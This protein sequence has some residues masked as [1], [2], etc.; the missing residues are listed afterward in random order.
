M[1][2][3]LVVNDSIYMLQYFHIKQN[4]DLFKS[5][6]AFEC[7]IKDASELRDVFVHEIQFDETEY[8]RVMKMIV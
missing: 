1:H 6:H 5:F 3:L 4:A 2:I 8:G 7:F